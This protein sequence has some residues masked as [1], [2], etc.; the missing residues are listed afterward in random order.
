MVKLTSKPTKKVS[1]PTRKVSGPTKKVSGP[2]KKVSGPTKKVS[3]PTKK[4]SGPTKKVSGPTKKVSTP[5]K[6][7]TTPTKKVTTPTKKVTTPTKKVTTPTNKVTTPT[8]KVTTPTK[9]MTGPINKVISSPGTKETYDIFIIAG[10]S[11][12]VGTGT[13]NAGMPNY[14]GADLLNIEDDKINPN[15]KMFHSTQNIIPAEPRIQ[16]QSSGDIKSFNPKDFNAS[17][18][19]GFGLTFAKEY[20]KSTGKKVLLVGCG[21]IGTGF[22]GASSINPYWWQPQDGTTIYTDTKKSGPVTSLYQLMKKKIEAVSKSVSPNSRI[23]G[24][25]WHQGESDV[26]T[27][28]NKYKNDIRTL[29]TNLRNYTKTLFRTSINIPVLIG[30]L[31][32][33]TYRNRI[34]KKIDKNS[35]YYKMTRFLEFSVV[36]SILNSRF[37]PAEPILNSKYTNFL[38]GDSLM[39]SN[40]E[41]ITKN[42]GNIHFSAT[43]QREFG[44]RYH[45]IFSNIVST[46]TP[47]KVVSTPGTKVTTKPGTKVTT[48]SGTKVTTKPVSNLAVSNL[49]TFN[50]SSPSPTDAPISNDTKTITILILFTIFLII[51]ILL[52]YAKKSNLI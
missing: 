20:Y 45:Y 11:N 40:G 18:K 24:I 32:P 4:V 16:H 41:E 12:A 6:K 49:P 38:E 14:F 31:C 27:D 17:R 19:V 51:I 7:V 25:L 8:K 52:A 39:N 3:G 15:I 13:R 26:L 47:I 23:C 30:G 44:K 29:F 2:T 46:K 5:T 21:Y 43:S 42:T 48:K 33:D 36:P 1:T 10:Q 37:V 9:K 50:K 35:N 22:N 28:T 34:L